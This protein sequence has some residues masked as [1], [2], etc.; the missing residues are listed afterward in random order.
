[1]L[2]RYY[3]QDYPIWNTARLTNFK[4]SKDCHD[5]FPVRM[6]FKHTA[7]RANSARNWE[8]KIKKSLKL[9]VKFHCGDC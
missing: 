6:S 8:H 3:T 1:M 9:L 7:P 2:K 4:Y 5:V